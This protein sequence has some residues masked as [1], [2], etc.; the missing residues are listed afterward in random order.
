[1]LVTSLL[2]WTWDV[3]ESLTSMFEALATPPPQKTKCAKING[4]EGATERQRQRD[5]DRDRDRQQ[6]KE[7]FALVTA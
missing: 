7:E 5:R 1:M 4:R 2:L 6:G 3:V